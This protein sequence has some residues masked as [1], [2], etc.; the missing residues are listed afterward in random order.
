MRSIYGNNNTAFYLTQ[1][2][3]GQKQYEITDHLG[4]VLATVS[5]ARVPADTTTPSVIAS[6]HP[7]VQ[8]AYDYYP[9]GEYMPGR[10]SSDTDTHCTT[11]TQTEIVPVT[12]STWCRGSFP[13]YPPIKT[14]Y[15]TSTHKQ[16]LAKMPA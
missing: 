8:S 12:T 10:Y 3:T 5:D 11:V 14:H 9:F 4:D 13:I 2:T 1:H 16:F 6:Y 15:K 7:V